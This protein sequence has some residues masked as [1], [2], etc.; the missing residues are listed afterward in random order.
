M[1]GIK[2]TRLTQ[3]LACLTFLY[4]DDVNKAYKKLAVLIHP[5]KSTAPGT[6]EAFKLLVNARSSL[7]KST[8]R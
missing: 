2:L 7:L 3:C 4:R 6:E 8:D 5:D 1:Q